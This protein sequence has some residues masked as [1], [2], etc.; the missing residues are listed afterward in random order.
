LVDPPPGEYTAHVVN[1]DQVVDRPD[2]WSLGE[3]R[4]ESPWPTTFGDKEAWTLTCEDA[5]GRLR[6]TRSLVI[7]R[8]DRLD[9]GNVCQGSFAVGAK[10]R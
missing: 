8:G 7:D 4:F 5:E 1:F 3:V 2:D 6:A 9:V 10:R